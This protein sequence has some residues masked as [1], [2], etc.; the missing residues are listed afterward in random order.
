MVL[1]ARA[2]HRLAV[3]RGSLQAAAVI[4]LLLFFSG[5]QSPL[6]TRLLLQ[7]QLLG[8]AKL[9]NFEFAF[10]SCDPEA[11]LVIEQFFRLFLSVYSRV[12]HRIEGV[13]E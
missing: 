13:G 1:Q 11:C 5:R 7:A 3:P 10:P 6:R 2:R 4:A 9:A 12:F 8:L